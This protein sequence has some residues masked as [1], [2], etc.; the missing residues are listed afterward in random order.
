MIDECIALEESEEHPTMYLFISKDDGY[1]VHFV[2][3]SSSDEDTEAQYIA[4][5]NG[6]RY[7]GPV[8]SSS[9]EDTEA[10]YIALINGYRYIGPGEKLSARD[11][12]SASDSDLDQLMFDI[13][14]AGSLIGRTKEAS[15]CLRS[16]HSQ[17]IVTE[18]SKESRIPLHKFPPFIMEQMTNQDCA[19]KSN[20][21]EASSYSTRK[22][23]N[24]NHSSSMPLESAYL[25]KW[26]R[27]GS[28]NT[29]G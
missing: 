18:T 20:K 22:S 2:V 12:G 29:S 21:G 19:I 27:N 6:Y 17:N 10:Q 4:L 5:I 3:G 9:D 13:D 28:N 7:I 11:L 14:D 1:H 24:A 23:K 16:K 15:T 26:E 25:S 8:G